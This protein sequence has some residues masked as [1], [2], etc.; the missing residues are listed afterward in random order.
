MLFETSTPPNCATKKLAVQSNK[1][2]G[3]SE[4][5]LCYL[6]VES[7][8]ADDMKFRTMKEYSNCADGARAQDKKNDIFALPDLTLP[9]SSASGLPRQTVQRNGDQSAAAR[10]RALRMLPLYRRTRFE[11]PAVPFHANEE[12]DDC[13]R[14]SE[15]QA[16]RKR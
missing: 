11:I 10:C 14:V 1:P 3:A 16:G 4:R 8:V 9:E 12:T 7:S 13:R 2:L 15:L 6:Q 5:C